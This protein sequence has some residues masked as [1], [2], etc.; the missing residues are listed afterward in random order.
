[1]SL[2]SDLYLALLSKNMRSTAFQEQSFPIL[3]ILKLFFS[4]YR[5][6]KQ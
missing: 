6:C 1:M 3:K 2:G 4:W 5:F